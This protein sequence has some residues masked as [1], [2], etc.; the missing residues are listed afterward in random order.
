MSPSA[1]ACSFQ[2]IR[3]IS[4]RLLRALVTK[5][6]KQLG[7]GQFYKTTLHALLTNPIYIGK[8]TYHDEMYEGEHQAI[9]D[10]A[11]FA[12]VKKKLNSNRVSL[13][14]RIHGKSPGVLAGLLR[15]SACD[16]MMTHSTSGGSGR[17]K[18]YRYYVCN[19]ERSA[20]TKPAPGL[21]CQRRRLNALWWHNF[22][23][24]QSTR[25]YSMR[26]AIALAGPLTIKGTRF[27]KSFPY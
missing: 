15:C 12:A 8:V 21:H 5:T 14:D 19:K 18:R 6:D 27:G 9:V 7:G 24:S 16:S 23:R 3:L 1:L 17:G 20:A 4:H 13:G 22:S 2:A 10:P 26:P 25:R 11:V